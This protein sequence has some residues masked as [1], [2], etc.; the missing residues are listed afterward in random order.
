MM[1][2][3]KNCKFMK[4]KVFFFLI[5]YGFILICFFLNVVGVGLWIFWSECSLLK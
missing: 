5:L 4:N 2:F 1:N 3:L